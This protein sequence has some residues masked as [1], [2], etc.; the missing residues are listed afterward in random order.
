MGCGEGGELGGEEVWYI[1]M[2]LRTLM[3]NDGEIQGNIE[4]NPSYSGLESPSR[5]S[6]FRRAEQIRSLFGAVRN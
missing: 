6:P 5:A 4:S 3:S 2:L 1:P